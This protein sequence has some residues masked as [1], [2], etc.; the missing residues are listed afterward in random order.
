MTNYVK[1]ILGSNETPK[2]GYSVNTTDGFKFIYVNS[3]WVDNGQDLINIASRTIPGTLLFKNQEFFID[4]SDTN[5][6]TAIVRG[7]SEFRDSVNSFKSNVPNVNTANTFTAVNTF[8]DIII[9]N[10]PTNVK[11]PIR[12]QEFDTLQNTLESSINSKIGIDGDVTVNGDKT[13]VNGITISDSSKILKDSSG[14][15]RITPLKDNKWIYLESEANK[16]FIG[17]DLKERAIISGLKD[18]TSDT[19]A[20]NKRT[21]TNSIATISGNIDSKA[22]KTDVVYLTGKASQQIDGNISIKSNDN[23]VKLMFD[24]AD[25]ACNISIGQISASGGYTEKYKFG[26]KDNNTSFYFESVETD[27]N[28]IFNKAVKLADANISI[29]H[30]SQLTTKKFVVDQLNGKAPLGEFNTLK[31]TVDGINTQLTTINGKFNS[32]AP[33]GEFSTLQTKVEANTNSLVAVNNKFNQYV[34]NDVFTIVKDAVDAIPNK[35]FD[36]TKTDTQALAG[37]IIVKNQLILHTGRQ[38]NYLVFKTDNDITGYIGHDD[39]GNRDIVLRTNVSGASIRMRNSTNINGHLTVSHNATI[40]GSLTVN[41]KAVTPNTYVVT[42]INTNQTI[43]GS[44]TFKGGLVRQSENNTANIIEFK[45]GNT[46]TGY[47]GHASSRDRHLTIRTDAANSFI[48][49]NNSVNISGQLQINGNHIKMGH[50]GG[51]CY[52]SAEDSTDKTLHMSNPQGS[53]KLQIDMHGRKILNLGNGTADT[54]AVNYGQLTSVKNEIASIRNDIIDLFSQ[55]NIVIIPQLP[56]LKMGLY[57]SVFDN[58]NGPGTSQGIGGSNLYELRS[59]R[60]NSNN[61]NWDNSGNKLTTWGAEKTNND[62][63]SAYDNKLYYNPT[64]HSLYVGDKALRFDFSQSYTNNEFTISIRLKHFTNPRNYKQLFLFTNDLNGTNWKNTTR[65]EWAGSNFNHYNFDGRDPISFTQFN[66]NE[67]HTV[68]LAVR[69][70]QSKTYVDGQLCSVGN[71]DR[72][73]GTAFRYLILFCSRNSESYG[74]HVEIK[75]LR[76]WNKQ[77]TDSDIYYIYKEDLKL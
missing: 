34:T 47:I 70:R 22:N 29:D 8:N 26:K 57:G 71:L 42:N 48:N 6:G 40:D 12:K 9:N 7:L 68:T 45:T 41:G 73:I 18:P 23:A 19:E 59:G 77:L 16:S 44:I 33:L 43:E 31:S 74:A 20:V 51:V 37:G 58:P 65:V 75:S 28:F 14:N 61:F 24:A 4:Q 13:F 69:G 67:F 72:E 3:A 11:H 38:P 5:D 53:G 27:A 49:L 63:G 30:D 36:L 46:R 76:L 64:N 17:I 10:A 50:G 56:R 32:Y 15:L 60:N 35:Y 2:E 52:L 62:T 54:D 55:Q 21:L 1:S 25:R 66:I 39:G